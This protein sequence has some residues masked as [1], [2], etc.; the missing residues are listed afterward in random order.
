MH[1]SPTN[2]KLKKMIKKTLCQK[3]IG[4]PEKDRL[5]LIFDILYYPRQKMFKSYSFRF[6]LVREQLEYLE[7]HHLGLW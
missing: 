4:G 6:S 7:V 3:L 5:F 1:K 2:L